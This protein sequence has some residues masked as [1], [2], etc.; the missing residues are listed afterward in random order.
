[1][2]TYFLVPETTRKLDD[3]RRHRSKMDSEYNNLKN[4]TAVA[5]RSHV[6]QA[7]RQLSLVSSSK[8]GSRG[9]DTGPYKGL[10][11]T[12]NPAVIYRIGHKSENSG[13]K[14]KADWRNESRDSERHDTATEIKPST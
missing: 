13:H 5:M 4:K 2:V 3:Y 14:L 1:M 6:I 9:L 11:H 8:A 7:P 10:V 12:N